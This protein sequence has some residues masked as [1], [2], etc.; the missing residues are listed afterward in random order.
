MPWV[1]AVVVRLVVPL[2]I[3]RYPFWGSVLALF[4]D[5]VDVIVLDYLGVRDFGAYNEVDKLLDMYM[6]FMQGYVMLG[7]KE[8]KAKFIGAFLLFYRTTGWL[9]Y[10]ITNIR[11]LLFIFPNVFE[12]YFLFYLGY[13]SVTAVAVFSRPLR[14]MVMVGLLAALKLWQEYMLHVAQFPIYRFIKEKLFAPLGF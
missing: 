8:R 4:A 1:V 9:A 11:S 10:E 13:R 14:F 5:N 2:S 12:F 7:W 6:H 3:L